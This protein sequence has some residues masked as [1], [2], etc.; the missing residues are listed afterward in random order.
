MRC[1]MR[2]PCF[3]GKMRGRSILLMDHALRLKPE[4]DD[5]TGIENAVRVERLLDSAHQA[6][7]DGALV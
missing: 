1:N 3:A 6:H 4:S 5:A 2:C 7:F